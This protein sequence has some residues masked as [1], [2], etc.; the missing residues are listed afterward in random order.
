MKSRIRLT[1][2]MI[3]AALT[4]ETSRHAPPDILDAVR[5]RTAALP[6]S[7]PVRVRLSDETA[8]ALRLAWLLV[9]LGL[10]VA[11]AVGAAVVGSRP[12]SSLQPVVNGKLVFAAGETYQAGVAVA[13]NDIWVV[14][15]DGTNLAR[16]TDSPEREWGPVWSPNGRRIAFARELRPGGPAPEPATP[17]E[18]ERGTP[19]VEEI[20]IMNADG[21]GLRQLTHLNLSVLFSLA[22]SPDGTQLAF[23][24][25][26]G[27]SVINDDGTGAKLVFDKPDIELLRWSPD[28]QLILANTF[29]DA[30]TSALFVVDLRGVSRVLTDGPGFES[31][32]EWSADGR[33]VLFWSDPGP[34]PHPSPRV[35]VIDADGAN[36]LVL[37]ENAVWPHWSP[38]GRRILFT[39]TA[40]DPSGDQNSV[41]IMDADGT[42]LRTVAAAFLARGWSPD[43]ALILFS[44]RDGATYTAHPDG[45]NVTKLL[46]QAITGS[47]GYSWQAM[48]R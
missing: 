11:L 31:A 30:N 32:G 26:G 2:E 8:S 6:R 29:G 23:R 5:H 25:E 24:H 17:Q 38:D 18:R 28:G 33:R 27:L 10:L 15:P 47:A 13:E 40:G 12:P 14:D 43:G 41:S 4:A 1:D 16:L 34:A 39:S 22:W 44:G 45:S 7:G 48:E 37:A 42:N 36:R 35:E 3:R 21:S 46:D 9:L 19:S 20:F